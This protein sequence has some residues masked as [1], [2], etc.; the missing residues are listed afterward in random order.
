MYAYQ[1]TLKISGAFNITVTRR[2]A[3]RR[4]IERILFTS[5]TQLSRHMRMTGT[6]TSHVVTLAIHCTNSRTVA[7]WKLTQNISEGVSR[8]TMHPYVFLCW[9]LWLY[10]LKKTLS[11]LCKQS[12]E[13]IKA[14]QCSSCLFF[15]ATNGPDGPRLILLVLILNGSL[16]W[17][18]KFFGSISVSGQ[19]PTYP[20]PN[21]TTVNW[22]Q[23]KVNAGL[24]EGRGGW[25]VAQIL[26]LIQFFSQWPS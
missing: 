10:I 15:W 12:Y 11:H 16:F 3:R 5:I 6:Q 9:T 26:I 8:T 14:S 23:V 25:A 7:S 4:I 2:T 20:S 24:G 17:V 18:V 1:V 22:Q 21:S 13:E 19:L